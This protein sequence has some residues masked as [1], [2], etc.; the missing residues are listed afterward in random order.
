M[1][2]YKDN[3]YNAGVSEHEFISDFY[4]PRIVTAL[5]EYDPNLG[6]DGEYEAIA[7]NGL[8]G[9]KTFGAMEKNDNNRWSTIS[10]ILKDNIKNKKCGEQ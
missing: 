1:K 5:K 6:T 2:A 8:Q 3:F 7:W 10:S 9:T 4:I